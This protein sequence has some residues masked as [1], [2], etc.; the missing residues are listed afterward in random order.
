MYLRRKN[1]VLLLFVGAISMLLFCSC[2]GFEIE[3]RFNDDGSG[4][5]VSRIRVSKLVLEMGSEEETGFDIPT[6]KE[7]IESIFHDRQ[8]VRLVEVTEEETE[9]DL[10]I[11][12]IIE[13]D[14]FRAAVEA[15]DSPLESGS[16]S[17]T[18]EGTVFALHVGEAKRAL[19]SA[20]TS[21]VGDK[22][23]DEATLAMVQAF[24]EGY[25][26]TYRIVAPRSIKRFSHG[27]I[28]DDGTSLTFEMPMADYVVLDESF[29]FEVVW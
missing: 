14:S 2:L 12:S 18:D 29:V 9:E 13:F 28:S 21:P 22:G 26:M 24:L 27:T 11:T 16:V 7:D 17:V 23:L 5:V 6:S 10:V 3:T 4:T 1:D 20:D 19:M 25:T 8:G 15:E